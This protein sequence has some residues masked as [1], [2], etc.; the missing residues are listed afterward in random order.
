MAHRIANNGMR[1]FTHHQALSVLQVSTRRARLVVQ[2]TAPH[3]AAAAGPS[4]DSNSVG[5]LLTTKL[6]N[7]LLRRIT[8]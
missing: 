1:N 8:T 7:R 6:T 5:N 4:R 2:T 3:A